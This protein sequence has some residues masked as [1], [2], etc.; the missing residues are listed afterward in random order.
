MSGNFFRKISQN[1]QKFP[2][3]FSTFLKEKRT[4]VF[5]IKLVQNDYIDQ[6]LA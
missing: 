4:I 2:D 6:N 1:C 3:I 5:V